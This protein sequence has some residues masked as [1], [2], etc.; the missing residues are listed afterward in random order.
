[1]NPA[2]WPEALA[3]VAGASGCDLASVRTIVIDCGAAG[4]R[5]FTRAAPDEYEAL[6]LDAPDRPR[7][8]RNA[9]G[10]WQWRV[11]AAPVVPAA[12]VAPPPRDR[13]ACGARVWTRGMCG[14]CYQR[15]RREACA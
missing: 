11:I 13:C 9:A 15:A 5:R 6:D 10:A 3:H 7:L 2:T 4:V 12:P 14:R 1:M 8:M